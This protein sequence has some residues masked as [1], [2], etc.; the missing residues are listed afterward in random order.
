MDKEFIIMLMAEFL[1]ECG[2]RTK[3]R[4]SEF[5]KDPFFIKDNGS[6]ENGRARGFLELITALLK[7]ILLEEKLMVLVFSRTT[8]WYTRGTSIRDM[9]LVRRQ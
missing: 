5:S 7:D 4:V 9:L 3:F 1:K 2:S 8:F 6:K